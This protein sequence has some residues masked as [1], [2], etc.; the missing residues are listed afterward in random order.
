[1]NKESD[2]STGKLRIPKSIGCALLC[3]TQFRVLDGCP[4]TWVGLAGLES[5][6]EP[7]WILNGK[8]DSRADVA[9]KIWLRIRLIS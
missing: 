5:L 2:L 9:N 7:H 1:M 8:S 6:S 4:L 3:F